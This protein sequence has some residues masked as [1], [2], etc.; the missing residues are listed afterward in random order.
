MKS[1]LQMTKEELQQE[2]KKVLDLFETA[3][4]KGLKLD[5]S[6][7]KPGSDQLDMVSGLASILSQPEDFYDG[8]LDVRNYGNLSGIPSAKVLFA[9]LFWAPSQRKFLSVEVPAFP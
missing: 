2:Q 4:K 5:M 7:G 1:Y 3:K 8:K 6:R 9:E